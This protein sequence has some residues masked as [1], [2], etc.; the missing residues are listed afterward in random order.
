[1]NARKSKR[2]KS[3]IRFECWKS[4]N[5]KQRWRALDLNLSRSKCAKFDGE[6][7]AAMLPRATSSQF[8]IFVLAKLAEP[9]MVLLPGTPSER[10]EMV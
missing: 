4:K 8:V 2:R 10:V 6:R 5:T 1:M 3:Q 7:K 9:E